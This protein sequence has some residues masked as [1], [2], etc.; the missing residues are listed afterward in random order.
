ME[1]RQAAL[2]AIKQVVI[3]SDGGGKRKPGPGGFGAVL[4]CGKHRKEISQ[5]YRL[6]TNNRM[7]L[8]RRIT[9][10]LF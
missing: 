9:S 1:D 4:V 10:P 6:T 7:E 2:P 3:H 5:G 8:R